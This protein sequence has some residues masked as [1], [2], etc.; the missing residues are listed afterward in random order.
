MPPFLLITVSFCVTFD[1]SSG[2]LPSSQ[3]V[4]L[5]VSSCQ[6]IKGS[7]M[8]S[9]KWGNH[10]GVQIVTTYRQSQAVRHKQ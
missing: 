1:F 2:A 3:A 7:F 9:H 6:Q 8:N 5:G 10:E 4:L